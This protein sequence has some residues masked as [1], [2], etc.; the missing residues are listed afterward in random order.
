M[1]TQKVVVP[2]RPFMPL[3]RAGNVD[4]PPEWSIGILKELAKHFKLGVPA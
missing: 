3:N 1:H 2:A 4:L